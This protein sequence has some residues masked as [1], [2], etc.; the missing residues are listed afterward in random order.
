MKKTI[1]IGIGPHTI[2][3]VCTLPGKLF[4]NKLPLLTEHNNNTTELG[5]FYVVKST[6]SEKNDERT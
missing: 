5:I 4:L 2:A 6:N 1:N 3:D